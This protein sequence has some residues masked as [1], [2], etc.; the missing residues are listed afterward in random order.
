MKSPRDTGSPTSQKIEY[1]IIDVQP[2]HTM[3]IHPLTNHYVLHINNDTNTYS[4]YSSAEDHPFYCEWIIK[5]DRIL[6]SC[7]ITDVD[8]WDETERY[9]E[10]Q[11]QNGPPLVDAIKKAFTIIPRDIA[12]L[13]SHNMPCELYGV[14]SHETMIEDPSPFLDVQTSQACSS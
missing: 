2:S 9:I 3:M 1:I 10:E 4:I 6:R 13:L 12:L 8:P 7:H 5:K 11:K 14:T